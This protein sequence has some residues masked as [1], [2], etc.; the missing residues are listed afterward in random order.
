MSDQLSRRQVREYQLYSRTSGKH[1]QVTGER[2]TATAEDGNKFGKEPLCQ[3][4]G[5]IWGRGGCV[6]GDRSACRMSGR[7][8]LKLGAG[9]ITPKMSAHGSAAPNLLVLTS[10]LP[11][12]RVSGQYHAA[13]TLNIR[14]IASC[15]K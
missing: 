5:G 3:P 6:S 15:G 8:V 4:P 12:P 7:W 11:N 2:I 10:K 1:V 13:K 14:F 9:F